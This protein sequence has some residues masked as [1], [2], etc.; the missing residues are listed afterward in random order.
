MG[1]LI[2]MATV[3]ILVA[4]PIAFALGLATAVGFSG[5]GIPLAS[6]PISLFGGANSSSLIALPLFL[7]LGGIMS[8]AGLAERLIDLAVALVGWIRGGLGIAN[9]VTNL[10]FAEISGSGTADA[11]ALAKI[12]VPQME[13]RGYDR[14]FSAAVT[15]SASGMAIIVPPSVPL[16]IYGSVANTSIAALFLAGIVPGLLIALTFGILSYAIARRRHYPAGDRFDLHV[17]AR[18]LRRSL[19]TFLLPVVVVG[20]IVFGVASP[21]ETAGLAGLI[22]V[23]LG[24]FVYRTLG[25]RAVWR[26][27]LEAGKQSAAVMILVAVSSAV[28]LLFARE[29]VVQSIVAALSGVS[30]GSPLGVMLLI[31][32]IL[33]LVGFVLQAVPILVIVVPVLLPAV[34]AVGFDRVAFGIVTCMA[35]AIGQQTPPVATT[36]LAVAAVTRTRVMTLFRASWAFLVLMIVDMLIVVAFP[37][38]A[39]LLPHLAGVGGE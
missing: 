25:G 15:S 10:I 16:V 36:L 13:R 33:L 27:A 35:I 4:V 2:L 39:T 31:C 32:G 17:L 6:L 7:F 29:R 26:V 38:V 1:P 22:G 12:F 30:Q 20:G 18:A 5:A 3:L 14:Q 19:L 8:E 34:D 37:Q 9:V 23:V 24:V 21:N 11:V 28:G